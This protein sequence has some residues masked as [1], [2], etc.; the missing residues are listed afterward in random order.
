MDQNH[1]ESI[2]ADLSIRAVRYFDQAGST[3]DIAAQWAAHGAPDLALVVADEQ[4]NGRGRGSRR[5][6]T[7]SGAALAFSIVVYPTHAESNSISRMTALGALAVCDA[8]KDD[9][10][11]PAKIKWPNDVLVHRR[12]L[13]G[14][15]VEAQWTGNQPGPL[16]VGIGINVAPA[17]VEAVQSNEPVLP[18]PATCLES[19]LGRSANRWELLHKVLTGVIYWRARLSSPDF[20]QA[21]QDNLAYQDEWVQV[22]SGDANEPLSDKGKPSSPIQEGRIVGLSYDGSLNIRTRSGEIIILPFGEVRLRPAKKTTAE[23]EAYVR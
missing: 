21:W 11:L 4:T 13:A 17:S 22:V 19:S 20:L 16:I 8:L 14:I 23:E 12:K 1:L 3:N 7:P 15:L 2:L 10:S 5:W 9:Y 18:V 6:Y